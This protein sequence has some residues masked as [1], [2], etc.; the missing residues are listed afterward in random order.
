VIF[1]IV[2]LVSF[3]P[4]SLP[5]N[6]Q[7][8]DLLARTFRVTFDISH[9]EFP[10]HCAI[11]VR[12]TACMTC[13]FPRSEFATPVLPGGAIRDISL[14]PFRLQFSRPLDFL[15]AIGAS[16]LFLFGAFWPDAPTTAWS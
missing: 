11:Y 4:S 6:Q 16:S 15:C 3:E 8:S 9:T 2:S 10:D 12:A 14:L 7:A 13:A 5:P 1:G